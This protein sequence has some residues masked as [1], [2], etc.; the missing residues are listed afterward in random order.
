MMR[1][2]GVALV[3]AAMLI[4]PVFA[5]EAPGEVSRE[6]LYESA[7]FA[8]CHASTVA[9]TA[10]GQLV[11]AYFAGVREGDPSVGIWV[12]RRIEGHWTEPLEVAN[13]DQPDGTRF[14]CWNPVLFQPREGALLL[15]YKVGPSP[16]RWWGEVRTSQDAGQTWTAARRLPEGI[17][18]PIKNKPIELAEG[19]LLCPSS[20]EAPRPNGEKGA[21]WRVHFEKTSDQGKTWKSF[22]PPPNSNPAAE[23]N[24]IQ[25]SILVHRDGRLQA[26]GRTGSK[27]LFETW[28]S[29]NG[30]TW[31]PVA[32]T[33]LPNPNSGIDALTLADGRFLVVYNHTE[34]GRSP[35][36]LAIS[37]DGKTWDAALVLEDEP[38]AEFSYPAIIQ[39][40]D[41]L[42]HI[43]YTWKRQ[44]VSH[45][46][47][48]PA[49]LRP[50]PM[51]DGAWPE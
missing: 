26:L 5:A 41:G 33:S 25:P 24:A 42:V 30:A 47:V 46:V 23:P 9:E 28:S 14:P 44:R 11:A 27:R 36:N 21:V 50:R 51:R 29:D 49:R 48:D 32:L 6:Y 19:V 38:R 31:S 13:G 34:R 3:V 7:P 17:L 4:P 35:L 12:Q 18:G 39:T 22:T 43:T 40:S 2:A 16:M 15:F 1:S 10:G 20:T 45:V 8:S 37:N